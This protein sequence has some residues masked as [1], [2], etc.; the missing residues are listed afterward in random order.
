M[1][2][3][4]LCLYAAFDKLHNDVLPFYKKKKMTVENILTNNGTEFK[5]T[6]TH[7]YEFYLE[8]ND[9]KHRTT[10]VRRPQTNGFIERFNRTVLDELF[11]ITFRKKM[12]ETVESLQEYLDTWLKFYNT[13]RPHQGYRNMGRKP[14]ET[15]NLFVQKET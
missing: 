2:E 6:D 13:N 15:I 12:Y 9:I 8:L 11:R 5:G 14:I 10:R 7:P 1:D 3:Q 4:I